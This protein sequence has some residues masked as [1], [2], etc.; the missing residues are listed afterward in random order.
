MKRKP[1]KKRGKRKGKKRRGKLKGRKHDNRQIRSEH[2]NL[3][4]QLWYD[5]FSTKLSLATQTE[6]NPGARYEVRGEREKGRGE[7]ESG[8][9]DIKGKVNGG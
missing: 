3:T 2:T 5:T 1:E 9:G 4:H 8:I 7:D 6:Q